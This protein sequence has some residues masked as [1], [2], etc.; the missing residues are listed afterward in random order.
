MTHHLAQQHKNPTCCM[1]RELG[2]EDGS[3]VYKQLAKQVK[4]F[5]GWKRALRPQHHRVTE[6]GG[7][8]G[9]ADHDLDAVQTAGT[10]AVTATT[11]AALIGIIRH[12]KSVIQFS[13]KRG[14]TNSS[15]RLKGLGKSQASRNRPVRGKIR[16]LDL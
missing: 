7:P 8:P 15:Q 11:A 14:K 1:G 16:Q 10:S 5:E 12:V 6:R 3:V 13:R 9:S 4:F 2:D